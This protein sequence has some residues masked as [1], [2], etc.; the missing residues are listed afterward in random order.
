[1]KQDDFEY[2]LNKYVGIVIEDKDKKSFIVG[3]LIKATDDTLT[4]IIRDGVQLFSVK[5]IIKVKEIK[6]YVEDKPF[7]GGNSQ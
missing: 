6:N 4:I 7:T 3:K 2:F 1:M 5:Y